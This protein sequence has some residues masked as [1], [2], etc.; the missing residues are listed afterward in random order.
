MP[1]TAKAGDKLTVKVKATDPRGKEKEV[2]VNVTVK[3]K[4]E[5]PK[6]F[7]FS[8]PADKTIVEKSKDG[9]K[10][11]ITTSNLKEGEKVSYEVTNVDGA[12]DVSVDDKGAVTVKVKDEAKAGQTIKFYIAAVVKDAEGKQV[13]SVNHPVTVKVV[14]APKVGP[15]TPP[16]ND[17]APS[18]GL[19]EKC[20]NTLLGAGIPLLALIPLGLL[21]QVAIGSSANVTNVLDQQIR[22][23]NAEIQRQAG[24]L[25][26]E[27]AKQVEAVD[28]YLTAFGYSVASA[29]I[30][31]AALA[32]GLTAS[33]FIIR[34]CLVNQGGSNSSLKATF[35]K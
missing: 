17:P 3:A 11:E 35:Q 29:A 31:L 26:P 6:V 15:S 25:N 34:D 8:Y 9:L 20:K 30:G 13:S 16:T 19:S 7:D 18:T 5:A 21:S 32:G 22:N 10:L 33:S 14:E 23:I 2:S 27:L 28:K 24:I 4:D 12:A 1:A